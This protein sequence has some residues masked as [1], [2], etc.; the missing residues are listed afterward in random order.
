MP[1]LTGLRKDFF[2][3]MMEITTIAELT[4]LQIEQG[5]SFA[6][7]HDMLDE[8]SSKVSDIWLQMNSKDSF[9]R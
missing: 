5:C 3:K 6:K 7:F 2:E 8:V 4:A 1:K 9:D